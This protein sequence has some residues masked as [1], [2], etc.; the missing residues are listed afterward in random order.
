MGHYGVLSGGLMTLEE[1]ME[2]PIRTA[3]SGPAGG[4]AAAQRVLSNL[5]ARAALTLDMG[6]TSTDISFV[7]SSGDWA[8]RWHGG[9]TSLAYSDVANRYHR[10]RWWI[11]RETR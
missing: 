5:D 3:I 11:Y 7:T 4:V 6:G 9:P 1:A 10:C 8:K 2:E